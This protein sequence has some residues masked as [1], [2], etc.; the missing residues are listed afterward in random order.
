MN[1]KYKTF[2]CVKK[3]TNPLLTQQGKSMEQLVTE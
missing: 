2:F 1:K 3:S